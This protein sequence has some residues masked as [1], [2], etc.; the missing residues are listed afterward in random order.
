[1]ASRSIT[2]RSDGVSFVMYFGETVTFGRSPDNQI[3]IG[4]A[5]RGGVEDTLVSRRAGSIFNQFPQVVVK[6]SSSAVALDIAGLRGPQR[7][8]EPGDELRLWAQPMQVSI[9]GKHHKYILDVV[10][11]EVTDNGAAH[12]AGALTEGPLALSDERRLD[13]AALCAPMLG[14]RRSAKAA[15]YAEAA[16]RRGISRKAMEKRTEHLIADLRDTNRLPGLEPDAE[17]K[18]ALCNYAVRTG[19]VTLAD[20]AALV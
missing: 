12:V 9:Q 5:R 19:T 2:V 18:Q 20:V 17:V 8:V 1:M 11:E 4:S 16:A 14:P 3:L 10:A 6:N 13:L 7:R 15:S